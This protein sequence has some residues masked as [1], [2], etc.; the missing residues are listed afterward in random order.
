MSELIVLGLVPGT[1][2]QITFFL[3][4]VLSVSLLIVAFVRFHR[5]NTF[6]GW[7]VGFRLMKLMRQRIEY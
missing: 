6:R 3:W 2:L 1:Q 4:V 5:K 7:I